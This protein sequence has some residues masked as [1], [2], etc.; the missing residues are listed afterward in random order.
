MP[1]L[2][3]WILANALGELLGLGGVA[4]LA[5][6]TLPAMERLLAGSSL[7]PLVAAGWLVALGAFE[8][9]VVGHAQALALSGTAIVARAWVRATVLG[10]VLAWALGMLPSTVMAFLP[11]AQDAA[12]GPGPSRLVRLFLASSLGLVAG[13]ILAAVQVRELRR[14]ARRPGLWLLANALGWAL[15]MPPVFAGIR[16]LALHGPRPGVLLGCAA[17]LFGAGAVVGLVEGLFLVR[18]LGDRFSA[19]GDI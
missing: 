14:V 3:R 18:M 15:G 11:H 4:F 8:G 19:T 17:A 5:G 10:A 2:R 7:R 9:W 1:L 16:A 12:A 13:P 6:A